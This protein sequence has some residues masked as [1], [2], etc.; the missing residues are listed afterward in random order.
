MRRR[1][2]R[3]SRLSSHKGRLSPHPRQDSRPAPPTR[4]PPNPPAV[5]KPRKSM[6]LAK[7]RIKKGVPGKKANSCSKTYPS[8][9]MCTKWNAS[10]RNKNEKNG[11][12]S[13]SDAE[14]SNA[15]RSD[16]RMRVVHII[17]RTKMTALTKL[18]LWCELDMS[19]NRTALQKRGEIN[20]P[21]HEL[22]ARKASIEHRYLHGRKNLQEPDKQNTVQGLYCNSSSSKIAVSGRPSCL[23][24]PL[25]IPVLFKD[26]AKLP[27]L[28]RAITPPRPSLSARSFTTKSAAFPTLS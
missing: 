16:D 5:V 4:T 2:S 19:E 8:F 12:S 27:S 14:E 10:H 26:S 3:K 23:I 18:R 22:G 20:A 15:G 11:L 25:Y 24:T 21:P 13:T 17:A 9:A 1:G 28:S 6:I 7:D